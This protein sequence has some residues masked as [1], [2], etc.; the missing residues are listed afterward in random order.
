MK[1]ENGIVLML[2]FFFL[3]NRF[4][5]SMILLFEIPVGT[6]SNTPQLGDV[7]EHGNQP[8]HN[9]HEK[10]MNYTWHEVFLVFF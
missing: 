6:R 7:W 10:L 1:F 2:V 8:A 5:V 3:M 4:N 9:V